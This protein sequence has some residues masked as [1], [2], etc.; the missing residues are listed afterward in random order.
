METLIADL[1]QAIRDLRQNPGFAAAAIVQIQEDELYR[2]RKTIELGFDPF[3]LN[4]SGEQRG[5][6]V[7]V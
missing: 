2:R 3:A 1:R 4:A 5:I 6:A 7:Q